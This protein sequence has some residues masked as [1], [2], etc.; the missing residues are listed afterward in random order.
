[1]WFRA[2]AAVTPDNASAAASASE[3][4][5]FI[6]GSPR[7]RGKSSPMQGEPA[8]SADVSLIRGQAR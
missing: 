7:N 4:D 2:L 3:A 6:V 8:A 5:F 1:M